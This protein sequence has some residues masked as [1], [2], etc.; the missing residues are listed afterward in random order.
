MAST[1]AARSLLATN[2]NDN[3]SA[4]I[5]PA[6]L[7]AVITS[8]LDLV[9]ELSAKPVV[10]KTA[11]YTA[12]TSEDTTFFVM[13]SSSA[14]TFTVP[15]AAAVGWECAVL[16]IGIGQTTIVASGGSIRNP[17]THTKIARQYGMVFL[18]VYANAGN[19]PQVV[20]TGDTST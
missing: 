8:L 3:T 7:R 4:D 20:M 15:A 12:L 5:T 2:I 6:E 10:T 1:T 13:D 9:D 17:D 11:S 14:T 16:Q 18:K 19:A